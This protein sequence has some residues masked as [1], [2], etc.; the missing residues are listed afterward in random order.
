MDQPK[1]QLGA[2]AVEKLIN[3]IE[4]KNDFHS[5]ILENELII[6]DSVKAIR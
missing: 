3:L 6:R 4:K 1:Y 5:V 2:I